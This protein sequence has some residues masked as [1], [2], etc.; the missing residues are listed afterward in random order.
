MD[1][2]K[3]LADTPQRADDIHRVI[4]YA[5]FCLWFFSS[6]LVRKK[7]FWLI[8]CVVVLRVVKAIYNPLTSQWLATIVYI[9]CLFQNWVNASG[10][11]KRTPG[12]KPQICQ[13]T[14]LQILI[15]PVIIEVRFVNSEF[16]Q[17]DGRKKRTAKRFFFFYKRDRAITCV[18][19]SWSSVIIN[20][21]FVF[22]DRKICYKGRWRSVE[23]FSNKI[24]VTLGLP[25]SFRSS[26]VA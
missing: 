14:G 8:F 6:A 4:L 10:L 15:F 18:F 22:F 17:P 25:S 26:P 9:A 1:V 2:S 19:L 5:Y 24:I 12:L 11:W 7:I 3:F 21:F 13:P 20:F 16:T 23:R